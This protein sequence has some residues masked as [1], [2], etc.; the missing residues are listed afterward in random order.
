MEKIGNLELAAYELDFSS[1][2]WHLCVLGQVTQFLCALGSPSRSGT[3]VIQEWHFSSKVSGAIQ[4]QGQAN[5]DLAV[6]G[7]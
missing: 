3:R 4:C 5:V 7:T 1:L 6:A 2:M